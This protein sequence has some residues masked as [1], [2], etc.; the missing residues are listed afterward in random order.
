MLRFISVFLLM[1]VMSPEARSQDAKWKKWEVEADT[2]LNRQ[3]YAGALKLYDKVIKS[4]GLKDK[5]D[6]S[7]LY[8]RAVCYYSLSQYDAALKDLD[9]F[10]EVYPSSYQATVLRAFVFRDVEDSQRQLEALNEAL[11]LRPGEPGL[12]Q[13]RAGIYL[14]EEKFEEAKADMLYLRSLQES[15]EIELYLG[16]AYYNLKE[17]D[18][19]LNF[20]NK[21]IALEPTYLPAYLYG[22]SFSLQEGMYDL[23]VKYLNVALRLDAGNGNALF[24]K[25]IALIE[26]DRKDE[27]CTFLSRAF[28]GGVDDAGDYLKE[29]CYTAGN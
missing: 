29:Y 25:G 3:D 1:V 27:G 22:G 18:S 9:K 24:Y 28:Y 15:P 8:K 12:I 13:W 10:R 17:A 4:S 5:D 2:L 21:A 20:I 14:E 11:S 6:F 26:L 16:L 23:A 19:A 7:A